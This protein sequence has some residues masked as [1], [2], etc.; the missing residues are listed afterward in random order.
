MSYA[1]GKHRSFV[2]RWSS[3]QLAMASCSE[4]RGALERPLVFASEISKAGCSMRHLWG[5]RILAA[6]ACSIGA[7][8]LVFGRYPDLRLLI[9][10]G[11]FCR[12]QPAGL[13][14]SQWCHGSAGKLK[15]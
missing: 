15:R 13:L 3:T 5:L 12:P 7:A 14:D 8:A 9:S 11:A 4:A 1:I 6:A 2:S 10:F